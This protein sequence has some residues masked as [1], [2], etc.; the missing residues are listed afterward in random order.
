MSRRYVTAISFVLVSTVLWAQSDAAK[1]TSDSPSP[2]TSVSSPPSSTE[3]QP[4]T[5]VLPDSTKLELIKQERAV[6]PIAASEKRLQGQVWIR[7]HISVT[8]DVND[9]DV[10]SGDPILAQAAV[11]ATKKWK[12]KPF[13]K[14]GHAVSVLYKMPMDFAFS[15][16]ITDTPPP[17]APAVNP[18]AKALPATPTPAPAADAPSHT[19]A[20]ATVK[21]VRV[22]Y[23]VSQGLLL[24]KVAPVYPPDARRNRIQGTVVLQAEIDTN[25]RVAILKV[26]SGPEELTAAAV[27]AVQ[28]WRYKPYLLQ[29][30]PV[31]VDTQVVVNFKLQ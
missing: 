23:G 6:Y 17:P 1:P 20:A 31:A 27:G 13:I 7:L 16:N 25:G 28:Q 26:I 11:S 18:E 10:I 15:G 8:G 4:G 14:N 5:A 19:S 12:F 21:K 24:H 30:N 22:S 29:G 3:T 2:A 9:V